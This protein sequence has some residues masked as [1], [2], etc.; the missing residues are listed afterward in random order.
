MQSERGR[1]MHSQSSETVGNNCII[2][3]NVLF[4]NN[5]VLRHNCI[6]EDNVVLGDNVY[7]DSNTIVR[8]N[9]TLGE[10]TFVGSNCIIGEYLMDF[11]IERK[12]KIH[13]LEIGKEALIRSGTIIYGDSVIGDNF[14]TGH[15]V[16][17]REKTQIGSHVSVGTLSD[18]QDNCEIGN[19]VRLHSN[20]FMGQFTKLKDFVWIFPHV[21]FTNDP[22]PPSENWMG[23]HVNSFAVIAAGAIIMPGIEIASDSLVGAGAIVTK[24][25]EQYEVVA[26]NPAK[27]ISDIRNIKDK[28]TGKECYPWRYYFKRAMPWAESDFITWYDSLGI[29]EKSVLKVN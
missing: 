28:Q 1:D 5:V 24:P 17:I 4:G 27:K 9:V 16:T 14:Q 3:K 15:R 25:V 19:Y 13:P 29:E 21:I 20:V 10:N 23:V 11:C 26:G 7:I 12:E 2:G 22:T 18:I 6:I 8:S